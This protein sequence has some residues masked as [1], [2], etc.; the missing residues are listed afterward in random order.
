[1]AQDLQAVT[2]P[3]LTSR[4]A[5]AAASGGALSLGAPAHSSHHHLHHTLL[6]HS[7]PPALHHQPSGIT[8]SGT[9]MAGGGGGGSSS[10]AFGMTPPPPELVRA[11]TT[12][13][14]TKDLSVQQLLLL[15]WKKKVFVWTVFVLSTL[16]FVVTG[17]QYWV[18]RM[19]SHL[20]CL[21]LDLHLY[22]SYRL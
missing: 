11:E 4:A 22:R 16:Y 21:W 13:V 1:M 15:L 2:T 12:G 6:H 17:I 3:P 8:G 5:A 19:S 18:C 7:H 10:G 9:V 20:A 14:Q